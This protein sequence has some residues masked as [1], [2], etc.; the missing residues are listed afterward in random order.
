MQYPLRAILAGLSNKSGADFFDAIVLN[1]QHSIGS[2]YCYIARISPD[3]KSSRTMSMVYQG[4]LQDNIEYDLANT[5]CSDVADTQVCVFDHDVCSVYPKDELLK[6]LNIDG[7][8]GTV[9]LSADGGVLGL[10]VALYHQPVTDVDFVTI[11][12]DIFS[13]RISAEIERTE[14]AEE[15]ARLNATLAQLVVERTQDLTISEDRL[16]ITQQELIQRDKM[17]S[18][19]RVVAAMAHEMSTPIGV[20]MLA[21][22]VGQQALSTLMGWLQGNAMSRSEL[23]RVVVELKEATDLVEM[24]LRKTG[25]L[26]ANFKN[27]VVN[28]SDETVEPVNLGS[29]VRSI[30]DSLGANLAKR[31]IVAHIDIAADIA[32]WTHALDLVQVLSH[33]LD[34]AI[35]HGFPEGDLLSTDRRIVIA[36][37]EENKRV[38]LTVEDNG[39]GV[40]AA[41]IDQIFEPFFT[42]RHSMKGSGLGLHIVY[43]LVINKLLGSIQVETD[44]KKGARFIMTIPVGQPDA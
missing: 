19:G 21:N 13:S 23:N 22:S 36:G 33:L 2:D 5:P 16:E 43:N 14:Q 3:K 31:H 9:L 10:L 34:N 41:H 24:N 7:Y 42:T 29:A 25:D 35:E 17:G 27:I 8:I 18:L 30:V 4:A 1:L 6:T 38:T 20:A 32:L 11:L 12:F 44:V 37:R 39:V 28:P 26:M 15:L 40:N